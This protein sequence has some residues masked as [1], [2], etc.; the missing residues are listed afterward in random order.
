MHGLRLFA[1]SPDSFKTLP[2]LQ[3][4]VV[5]STFRSALRSFFYRPPT[6]LSAFSELGFLSAQIA[7]MM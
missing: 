3:Q 7:Y 5:A 6:R 1:K 2:G 4:A